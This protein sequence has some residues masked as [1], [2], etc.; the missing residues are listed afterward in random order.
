MA[1]LIFICSDHTPEDEEHKNLEFDLASFGIIGTQTLFST[2]NKI[3]SLS[4]E[5]KI[6]LIAIKPRHI[7][8]IKK[9]KIEVNENANLTLFNPEL[10]YVLSAESIASLSKNTPLLGKTLK[11]KALGIINKGIISIFEN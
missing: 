8:G 11:G 9:P 4:L 5:E 2:I 1:Q 10:E 7:M 3:D 6:G